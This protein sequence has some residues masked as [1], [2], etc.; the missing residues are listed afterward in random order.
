MQISS[1][2]DIIDGELLNSPSISFIYSIKTNVSKVKEGDLFIVRNPEDIQTAINNGAFALISDNNHIITD[3]EIAWIKVKNINNSIIQLIR[4]K[5]AISDLEAYYCDDVSFELLKI[6]AS[7]SDKNI[8]FISNDVDKL[9]KQIEDIDH[10]D[11]LICSNKLLLDKIYPSNEDFSKNIKH[12]K[13][14]NIIEHSLFECS[15]SFN[16]IYFQRIKIA[17]IY[18]N[19]FVN[20]Y[21]FLDYEFDFSKLKSFQNFKPIF[22]D[23]NLNLLEFGKSD[24]FVICQ[25]N[26]LLAQKEILYIK[27]K[28]KYAKTLYI[29]N[30]YLDFLNF[31]EQTTLDDLNNLKKILK[32]SS[33][34]AVYLINYNYDDVADYLQELEKP[35]SLF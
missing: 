22:L 34:N 3:N 10:N 13:I 21:K 16:D 33:F 23:K 27:E 9:F 31:D 30:T 20:V 2:L 11:I 6:F 14:D 7:S 19:E 4:F 35:L 18:I 26:I 32:S 5:L 8:K 28:Y 17:S 15:F 12:L 29:T 1:I 25:D 24:K